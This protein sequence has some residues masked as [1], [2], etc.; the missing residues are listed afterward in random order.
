MPN[1][2]TAAQ[3][4][5]RPVIKSCPFNID[6]ECRNC[7]LYR[8]TVRGIEV[9]IFESLLWHLQGLDAFRGVMEPPMHP[10]GKGGVG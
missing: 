8:L 2:T 3:E 1:N 9:C 5:P 10:V 6:L 7:R 4:A